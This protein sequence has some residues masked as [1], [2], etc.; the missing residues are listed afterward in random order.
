MVFASKTDGSWWM[1]NVAALSRDG[2]LVVLGGALAAVTIPSR[3]PPE[4]MAQASED[5]LRALTA[6]LVVVVGS[7]VGFEEVSRVHLVVVDSEVASGEVLTDLEEAVSDTV[8]GTVALAEVG[9]EVVTGVIVVAMGAARLH[10]MHPQAQAVEVGLVTAV[11]LVVIVVG[12]ADPMVWIVVALPMVGDVA[13]LLTAQMGLTLVVVVDA[14]M[15]TEGRHEADMEIAMEEWVDL[16]V[17]ESRLDRGKA[18]GK[19]VGIVTVIELQM[20]IG[21]DTAA[22]VETAE[23]VAETMGTPAAKDI[24]TTMDEV[25]K[26]AADEDTRFLAKSHGL[27][28]LWG[29]FLDFEHHFYLLNLGKMVR[30]FR[31]C[32]LFPSPLTQGSNFNTHAD[33]LHPRY[34]L[35]APNT[36]KTPREAW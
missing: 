4:Q 36:F 28:G 13:G 6:L 2:D 23:E 30:N 3:L 20:V 31:T 17:T 14:H 24:L 25:I 34:S 35:Y 9:A 16:V 32:F 5:L 12:M 10:L 7:A 33:L 8:A 22:A 1:S 11:A 26:I 15:K 21:E 27:D 29:N 18:V 19:A